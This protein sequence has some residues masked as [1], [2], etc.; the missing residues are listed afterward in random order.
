MAVTTHARDPPIPVQ[1][2]LAAHPVV[3]EPPLEACLLLAQA[4]TQH[5]TKDWD[6]IAKLLDGSEYWPAEAGKMTSQGYEGAFDEIMRE[7]GL[8]PKQ[9]TEPLARP[10]RQLVHMLYSNLLSS[11]RQSILTSFE[12]EARLKDEIEAIR[13]GKMDDALQA[14]EA[15]ADAAVATVPSGS[16]ATAKEVEADSGTETT[17]KKGNRKSAGGRGRNAAGRSR[18][19]PAAASAS[20]EDA[21]VI[22]E[23]VEPDTPAATAT[24]G[25]GEEVKT[26]EEERSNA[27]LINQGDGKAQGADDAATTVDGEGDGD[28]VEGEGEVDGEEQ[29]EAEAEEE[30]AET[31]PKRGRGRRGTKATAAAAQK[32][33][34]RKQ[35]EPPA[36]SSPT[37]GTTPAA[38]D[39]NRR[40]KRVKTTEEPADLDE[41]DTKAAVQRRKVAFTRIVEQLQA[42]KYS[43]YF[44][45]RVTRSIAP[46]YNTAVRRPTCLKDVLKA[47]KS[48]AISNSTE[49]MRDVALL[50]ANAIQFNGDEGEESVGHCAKLLWERFERLVDETLSTLL[51]T[52]ES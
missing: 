10:S 14:T 50:C 32:S 45:S 15:E 27:A 9:C 4:V 51:A 47:I 40:R 21:M 6:Q 33:K 3:S 46:M 2:P 48:G 25:D 31:K 22:D 24:E 29:T 20:A 43:H 30:E 12:E 49:L 44:E 36:A 35:S 5:G 52:G 16:G 8:D 26:E 19:T 1:A 39:G 28:T 18:R 11:L 38:D 37:R 34:K 17:P 42:E 23:S 41:K 7:R 13:A